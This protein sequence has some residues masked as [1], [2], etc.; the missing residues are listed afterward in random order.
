MYLLPCGAEC[1]KIRRQCL[2]DSREFTISEAE[3]LA[4]ANGAIRTP[5]IKERFV[6]C[7]DHVNMF[8][9]MVVG[10]DDHS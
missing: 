7:P 1:R 10:T 9:P 3:V 6:L 5:Q 8:R 2:L 4:Q